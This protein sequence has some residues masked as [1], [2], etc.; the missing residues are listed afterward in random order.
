MERQLNTETYASR[1][2]DKSL[3]A[4]IVWIMGERILHDH[5]ET[6]FTEAEWIAAWKEYWEEGSN[7]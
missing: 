6:I 5:P 4:Y 2:R 7:Y 1:P 3:E